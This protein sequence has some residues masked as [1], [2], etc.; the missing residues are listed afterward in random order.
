LPVPFSFVTAD[1]EASNSGETTTVQTN[2]SPWQTIQFYR[3]S[4]ETDDPLAGCGTSTVAITNTFDG[5]LLAPT[6]IG[7]NPLIATQSPA[8][9]SLVIQTN[10]DHA[11]TT[12]GMALAF[13]IFE[14]VDRG[15]LPL[16]Y[17]TAWHKLLYAVSNPCNYNPPYPALTQDLTLHI[18]MVPGDA[19]PIQYDNDDSIGVDEEGVSTFVTYTGNGS[20]SVN[21]TLS[22]TTGSN[23][24]LTGWFDFNR[25]GT[26]EPGESVTNIIPNNATSAVLT[27]TGLPQYLPPGSAGGY[28]FRPDYLP[29]TERTTADIRWRYL[30]VVAIY[31]PF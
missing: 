15:D 27:W 9:G 7:Q 8:S 25:D 5:S 31:R 16:S 17:G 18:G 20:Y 23:A 11:G 13:G 30:C 24:Y 1:A 4:T 12:G 26:F 21:L 28:G 6:P 19:D 22:N 29:G 14:P 2:G 10:F 3:N